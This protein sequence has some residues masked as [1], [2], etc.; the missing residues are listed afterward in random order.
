MRLL[1]SIN[2]LRDILQN[3][4]LELSFEL[5]NSPYSPDLFRQ[6]VPLCRGTVTVAVLG[7]CEVG[8][9]NYDLACSVVP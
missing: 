9:G 8:V 1:S 2:K 3:P 7:Q 6:S 4:F 5:T